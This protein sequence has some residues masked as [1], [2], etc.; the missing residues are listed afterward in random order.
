MHQSRGCFL[1]AWENT[2]VACVITSV[3]IRWR[4]GRSRGETKYTSW[5]IKDTCY[6]THPLCINPSVAHVITSVFRYCCC[7]SFLDDHAQHAHYRARCFIHSWNVHPARCL[8][9]TRPKIICRDNRGTRLRH[10]RSWGETKYSD[11]VLRCMLCASYN[12]L[13]K[14]TS[15]LNP[16]CT[17]AKPPG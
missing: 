2:Q 17:I 16:P 3:F 15:L 7:K 11:F 9:K 10:S 13:A 12:N 6:K 4:H 1:S 5:L 14:P 8:N